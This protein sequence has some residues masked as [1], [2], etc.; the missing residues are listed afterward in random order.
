MNQGAVVAAAVMQR[1]REG[2][3]EKHFGLDR[4]CPRNSVFLGV[5]FEL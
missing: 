3:E 4:G 2:D 1:K 5:E